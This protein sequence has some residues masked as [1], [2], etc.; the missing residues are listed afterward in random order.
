MELL[1][2]GLGYSPA[3]K[4]E[5]GRGEGGAVEGGGRAGGAWPLDMAPSSYLTYLLPHH[6]PWLPKDPGTS[7]GGL[8][9]PL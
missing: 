9:F 8:T 2:L 7:R 4:T 3:N 6:Q 5:A 1:R